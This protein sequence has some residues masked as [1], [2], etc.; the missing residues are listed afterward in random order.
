L[1]LPYLPLLSHHSVPS[2]TKFKIP[3]QNFYRRPAQ[4]PDAT[5]AQNAKLT[6]LT[7]CLPPQSPGF[8]PNSALV[9]CLKRWH[10]FCTKKSEVWKV[11]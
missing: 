7:T 10:R 1:S 5:A 11:K 9:A 4:P 2:Q 8:P 3:A 6:G